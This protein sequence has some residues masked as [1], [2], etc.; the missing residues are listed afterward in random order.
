[1]TRDAIMTELLEIE[2]LLQ[3]EALNDNDGH[4]LHGAQQALRNILDP[5]TWH[6]ASQT[7]YRID[8]RHRPS[9]AISPLLHLATWLPF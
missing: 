1:M 3:D 4:A 8:N 5:E 2:G 7:F 9:E 6:R